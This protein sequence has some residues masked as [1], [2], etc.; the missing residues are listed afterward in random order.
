MLSAADN[1]LLTRTGA[2]T[3]MGALFRRF[4]TPVL[5]AQELPEPDCPPVRVTVMGEELIGFRDSNNRL[6]L[7][8][9][10]CPHR[11]ADLYFGRNEE[12]GLRCVFHGLK[13]DVAGNCLEAP[14]FPR[15]GSYE[16]TR[17]RLK[18][19]SYPVRE[20][21]GMIWAYMGPPE[22][23]SALP[24]LELAL[25]PA[26]HRFVSKKYQ[27]C[28]Y[29]QALEG[30]LDTAH[31]S[32]LHM[33]VARGEDETLAVMGRSEAAGNRDRVRWLRN[34]P[35]PRFTVLEHDAGLVIAASRRT[36]GDEL[37]WRI[38]QFLL[39]NHSLTPSAFP[40]DI[41]H[42]NSWVPIDDHSCWIYCYSW[43]PDRP[44]TAEEREKLR[45]GHTV[46]SEVDANWMPIRNKANNYR[47]DRTEQKL[48][49]FTGIEGVS[50][51]DAAIQNS[52][53]V[54]A[55]RTREFLGPTD[56]GIVR[57]RQLLLGS[58]K[59]LA[60]GQAPTAAAAPDAYR[61]RSGGTMGPS[62]LP[63]PEVM[64][65]RFGHPHGLIGAPQAHDRADASPARAAG[66]D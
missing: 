25:V 47:L 51:Q 13:F 38:S 37:Y 9:A 41:Y 35:S 10:H 45:R 11:G 43:H 52:Q 63:V 59:R 39:P 19:K 53:G 2:G 36:D 44:L 16:R 62:A 22:A 55:D 28:N 60:A 17:E 31:F 15:D 61:V 64:I 5:L 50:E 4:W 56:L 7:L 34:D 21:G 30:G 23:M 12:C 24:Q 46:H 54:I 57:F 58:A 65:R 33:A 40:G 27:E 26:S 32:F 66:G 1:E 29:A 14:I 18:L 48:R 8:E 42:G 3:P 20:W 49:S 6:G